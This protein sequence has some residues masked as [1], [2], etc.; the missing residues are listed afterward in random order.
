MGHVPPASRAPIKFQS[1]YKLGRK[2]TLSE[3]FCNHG[4]VGRMARAGG[5]SDVYPWSESPRVAL[6]FFQE[7]LAWE[8]EI[9]LLGLECGSRFS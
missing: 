2:H 4:G 7:V 3:D 1:G 6:V 5:M 9:P 8:P